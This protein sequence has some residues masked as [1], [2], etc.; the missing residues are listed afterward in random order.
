MVLL[1]TYKHPEYEKVW[2]FLRA[3]FNP[4]CQ[5]RV[6]VAVS[7]VLSYPNLTWQD[8]GDVSGGVADFRFENGQNRGR[9]LFMRIYDV[10]TTAPWTFYGTNI[11]ATIMVNK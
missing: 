2:R 8:L 6:Q 3:I 11:E 10:A 9:F 1:F 7:N 4:G 5:A